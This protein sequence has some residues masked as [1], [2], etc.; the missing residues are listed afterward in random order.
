MR[1]RT[2]AALFRWLDL[3]WQTTSGVLLRVENYDEWIIH[4][5]VFVDAEYD[6]A[7]DAAVAASDRARAL[8]IID[9]GANVG[10]FA[11]RVA[12]RLAARR[13]SLWTL[14]AIEPS[15]ESADEFRRRAFD[16]NNLQ[17]HVALIEGL[18]GERS[19]TA[20]LRAASHPGGRS[21]VSGRGTSTQVPFVDLD[22]LLADHSAIDL[23][24]CD[25][26]GAELMFLEQYAALMQKTR[27]VII[28]MH[29]ALCDTS[30]CRQLLAG[31]G[32]VE[33]AGLRSRDGAWL[34]LGLRNGGAAGR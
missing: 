27:V 1:A 16:D 32:F 18:V 3:S 29:D 24:K 23:I 17:Q 10:F 33:Q 11:L 7:I 26:E 28:E 5:E 13:H 6:R 14:T 2:R 4:E 19:G 25:V 34:Y 9:L 21:I 8:R 22:A 30:R 12:D 15:R 20:E 31:Y